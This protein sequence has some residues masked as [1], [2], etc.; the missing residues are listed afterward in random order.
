MAIVVK[1]LSEQIYA[2]VRD[3]LISGELPADTAIKQDALARELGVSKIPLREAFTRLERDGLLLSV[4]NRGFFVPPMSVEEVEEV[5]ALRLKLEPEA[6]G[7]AAKMATARD[8]LAARDALRSLE[9]S[10]TS[11]KTTSGRLHRDY[12][13]S[14]V[15]PSQHKITVQFIERLHMV[16]ERY[17]TK[18]LEPTGREGRA[19]RE[20]KAIFE[21]W[22]AGQSKAVR[23]MMR[24]HISSTLGD[25][26]KEF[27]I[28][29]VPAA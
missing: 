11:D 21:A 8:K 24:D 15:L 22:M 9:E 27:A 16:A 25:L 5:Y 18:H 17:V 12:H 29:K 7:R 6:A 13:M 2:V 26:R 4:T 28:D 3:R 10:K 20:H 23:T 19:K 14:L 1:T